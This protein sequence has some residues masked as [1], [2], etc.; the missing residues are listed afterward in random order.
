MDFDPYQSHWREN[1]PPMTLL[2]ASWQ[3]TSPRGGV[4]VCGHLPDSDRSR[5]AR[6]VW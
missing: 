2:E 5:G 4:L 6:R 3:M 1:V